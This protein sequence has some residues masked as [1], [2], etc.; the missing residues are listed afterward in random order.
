MDLVDADVRYIFILVSPMLIL[1]S[2]VFF[3]NTQGPGLFIKSYV[4]QTGLQK[5]R[6]VRFDGCIYE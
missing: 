5:R 4:Q 1:F 3:K 2:V 6:A